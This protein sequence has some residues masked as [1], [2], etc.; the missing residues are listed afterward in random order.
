MSLRMRRGGGTEQAP[1]PPV[2]TYGPT[3]GRASVIAG[4]GARTVSSPG[5]GI[6]FN[7]SGSLQS[8]IN[9]QPS[10]SVFVCSVNNPTW[11]SAVDTGT[12]A[13]TIV[14]PGLVGQIVA[15]GNGAQIMPISLGPN[16][17]VQGG[18][19][20]NFGNTDATVNHG[21]R[22]YGDGAVVEDAVVTG[23]WHAGIAPAGANN[24]RVSHCTMY[25][26]GQA[27]YGS[28]GVNLNLTMEYNHVFGNNTR[29]VN[30]GNEGGAG[31]IV[32]GGGGGTSG[33][34]HHNYAH[35]NNGFGIW[36]DTN[37]RDWLIEENV[38]EDNARSG[39]F[40]EA[41]QHSVIR[42]NLSSNN[43]QNVT[44]GGQAPSFENCI[45]AR[46]ADSNCNL[47]TRGSF[48]LNLIDYTL[49]PPSGNFGGI[50]IVWDHT[51]TVARSCQ[52]WDVHDNQ[53]WLR[54]SVNQRV[55]GQDTATS[56]FPV[57]DNNSFFG[58][59]YKVASLGNSY[60]KWDTGTGGGVSKTWAEWQGFHADIDR[61]LI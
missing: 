48:E 20:S 14:F 3:L 56:A 23:I 36:W 43:G 42:R 29:G 44:I 54:G 9:A 2:Q 16:A 35:D 27:G 34:F 58:N 28:N 52:N 41:S 30:P 38:S 26:N 39:I 50:F 40:Y 57:W 19:F 10:G 24:M 51:G 53:F 47:G 4:A 55:G 21:L 60:W 1:P 6:S 17:T 11:N 33:H 5:S 37:V 25:A 12:K 32:G 59:Q 49:A 61:S 31:K 15:N 13:P 18:T 46:I 22:M 7:S 45:Q 8:A